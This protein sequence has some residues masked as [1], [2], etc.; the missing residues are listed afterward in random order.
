MSRIGN[1]VIVLPAGVSASL[2]DGVMTVSGPKGTLTQ[3]IKA[4]ITAV[5]NGNEVTFVKD[6]KD[7]TSNAKQ[8]LYRE[9]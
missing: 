1:K 4:P 8:G 3:E 5:I 2:Q 6:E 9:C 7:A